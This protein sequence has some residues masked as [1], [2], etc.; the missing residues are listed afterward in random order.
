MPY[1]ERDSNNKIIASY[2]RKQASKDVSFIKETGSDYLSFLNPQQS[3]QERII[4]LEEEVNT[5]RF[6]RELRHKPDQ[7]YKLTGKTILEYDDFVFN[8]IEVLRGKL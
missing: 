8:E 2:A 1:V 6:Q 5:P 4:E 3:V 7:E